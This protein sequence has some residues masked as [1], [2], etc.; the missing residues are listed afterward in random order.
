V[1]P[2]VYLFY[3]L[4]KVVFSNNDNNIFKKLFSYWRIMSI[5]FLCVGI[6]VGKVPEIQNSSGFSFFN[7]YT[8]L[9]A[10]RRAESEYI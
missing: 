3:I 8:W 10:A 7:F 1:T 2:T 9:D 6:V 4:P 5:A